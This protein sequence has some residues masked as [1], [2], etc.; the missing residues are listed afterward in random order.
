VRPGSSRRRWRWTRDDITGEGVRPDGGDG[1]RVALLAA[2][3]ERRDDHPG[4]RRED[5]DWPDAGKERERD[6][7]GDRMRLVDRDR[8]RLIVGGVVVERI[9]DHLLL[10]AHAEPG[11]QG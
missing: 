3:E 4:Q 10:H 8:D 5:L 11:E 9:H 2:L 1:A 6:P 7:G